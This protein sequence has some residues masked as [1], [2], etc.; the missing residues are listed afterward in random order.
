MT[1]RTISEIDK[2]LGTNQPCLKINEEKMYTLSDEEE[3][4]TNYIGKLQDEICVARG[5][6]LPKYEYFQGIEG[7]NKEKK[8]WNVCTP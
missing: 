4:F 1:Q 5:W 6:S 2:N 8:I 3:M 7:E